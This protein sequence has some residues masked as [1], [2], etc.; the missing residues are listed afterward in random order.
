MESK[1]EYLRKILKITKDDAGYSEMDTFMKEY[2]NFLASFN[3]E[4]IRG[5]E[6]EKIFIEFHSKGI[7][8]AKLVELQKGQEELKKQLFQYSKKAREYYKS[9]I[10]E[11]RKSEILR[12]NKPS[13][14]QIALMDLERNHSLVG[15]LENLDLFLNQVDAWWSTFKNGLYETVDLI[16]SGNYEDGI[17]RTNE[18]DMVVKEEMT[19][20]Q[21]RIAKYEESFS[22]PEQYY[23]GKNDNPYKN[24]FLFCL[25]AY[26]RRFYPIDIITMQPGRVDKLIRMIRPEQKEKYTLEDVAR[27]YSEMSDEPYE[28]SYGKIKQQFRKSQFMQKYKKG[29]FY[30]FDRIEIPLATYIY[31]SKKNHDEPELSKLFYS[32]NDFIV[33]FYAPILKA[34]MC[35]EYMKIQALNRYAEFVNNEFKRLT[36]T[37]N[38]AYLD[39]WIE[40]LFL[41]SM[42]LKYRCIK[43]FSLEDVLR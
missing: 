35:G 6:I 12:T 43:G 40:E 13:E 26:I 18:F 37:V 33:H 20:Y 5:G 36:A 7:T 9:E 17:I 32:Y 21:T 42:H 39:T 14:A 15:A 29:R 11:K 19:Y 41:T 30:E 2:N 23:V 8:P 38:D 22:H 1:K 28:K 25:N 27:A 34:N 24:I 4:D 31:Y 10:L 16:F 3:F